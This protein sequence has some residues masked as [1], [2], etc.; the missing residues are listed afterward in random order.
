MYE[1]VSE[2]NYTIMRQMEDTPRKKNISSNRTTANCRAVEYIRK[3]ISIME[4]KLSQSKVI[5]AFNVFS[6]Y[7]LRLCDSTEPLMNLQSL[8]SFYKRLIQK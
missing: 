7:A 6:L 1:A 5:C 4:R 8:E 3:E 2:V